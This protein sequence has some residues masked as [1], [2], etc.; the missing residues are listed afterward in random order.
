MGGRKAESIQARLALAAR[1]ASV[2]TLATDV[3]NEI[4]DPLALVIT[5]L[6]AAI[7]RL[8]RVSL[9]GEA[10]PGVALGEALELLDLLE[11]A[12]EGAEQVRLIVRDLGAFAAAAGNGAGPIEPR[13]EPAARLRRGRVLIIDDEPLLARAIAGTLEPEHEAVQ[14]SSARDA[15]ARLRAGER[16]DV[17]LCD[18]MMP[19][20]T[21]M[22]L[23]D[24]LNEVAPEQRRRVIFLTGGAFTERARSFLEAVD[25]R[26]L[27]KPFNAVTLLELVSEVIAAP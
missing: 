15:L 12:R 24:A 9:Q 26:L 20:V 13:R 11:D 17:I 18:L 5:N 10:G 1:M 21:G 3:A 7:R 8:G 19:E 25:G 27:V 2:G 6:D 22:D 16:Y 4:D 14:A 23:Y